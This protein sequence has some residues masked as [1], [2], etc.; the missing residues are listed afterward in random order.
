MPHCR[1]NRHLLCPGQSIHRVLAGQSHLETRV[2]QFRH[3]DANQAMA[4]CEWVERRVV[5]RG[6]AKSL[7]IWLTLQELADRH[8]D[9]SV[10]RGSNLIA[11]PSSDIRLF[12]TAYDPLDLASGSIDV[13]GLQG[14]YPRARDSSRIC[15]HRKDCQP[16]HSADRSKSPR[17]ST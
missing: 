6:H 10:L 11:F 4:D 2:D 9:G 12:L 17:S 15:R 8:S 14:G 5:I 3:G 7:F 1:S 16:L 13:L